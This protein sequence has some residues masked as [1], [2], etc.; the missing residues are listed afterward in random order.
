MSSVLTAL[1]DQSGKVP[2]VPGSASLDQARNANTSADITLLEAG[3]VRA[4]AVYL[5]VFSAV[6]KT[7][8]T[9]G[10][11][12]MNLK[13]TSRHRDT[14]VAPQLVNPVVTAAGQF[15]GEF[16]F[17]PKENTAV[18]YSVTGIT[19]PGALDAR[20]YVELIRLK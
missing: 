19:T 13:Y 20:E 2:R 7:A 5:A 6:I 17:E 14:A 9:A 1:G 15:S 16:L 8:G 18:T 11:I 10:N 12:G 3:Q 4:G